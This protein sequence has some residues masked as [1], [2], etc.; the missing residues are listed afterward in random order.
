MRCERSRSWLWWLALALLI[1]APIPSALSQAAPLGSHKLVSLAPF[2]DVSSY[3]ISPDGLRVVYVADQETDGVNE[4]YSIPL[5]GGAS[6]KLNAPLIAGGDVHAFAV[7]PDGQRVV[8]MADQDTDD[9]LEFYSVPIQGPPSAGVKISGPMSPGGNMYYWFLVKFSPDSQRVVYK[10][11]QE[12]P[13]VWDLYSVPIVGPSSAGVKLNRPISG[14]GSAYTDYSITP[15]GSRVVF[16]APSE[17]DYVYDLYSVPIEGPASAAVKLNRTL[18]DG[19]SVSSGPGEVLI[20][21]DSSTVVYR[22]DQDRYRRWELY[23]VPI[24]GPASAG[25]KL[26]HDMAGDAGPVGDD[27]HY[28]RVS[29]DGRRVAF[30]A[31]WVNS[32]DAPPYT[33]SVNVWELYSVPIAGPASAEVKIY[34]PSVV[35]NQGYPYRNVAVA[36]NS[37]PV[38]DLSIAPDGARLV[39]RA[40]YVYTDRSQLYSIPPGGPAS[41]NRRLDTTVP[42]EDGGEVSHYQISPD[43]SRVVYRAD[44]DATGVSELYSVAV[45]GPAGS[46]I[47]L[48]GTLTSGGAVLN[49]FSISPDGRRVVYRADQESDGV[50]ELYSVPLSGPASAVVKLNGPLVSGGDVTGFALSPDGRWVVYRA[51]QDSNDVFELYA[52]DTGA[53]AGPTPTPTTTSTLT[54]TSSATYPTPTPTTTST[55]TP[56]RSTTYLPL[57]VKSFPFTPAAP[58]LNAI[59]NDDGD[60]TYTVSW[61]PSVGADTYTLQEASDAGFSDAAVVYVGPNTSASIRGRDVGTYYYRAQAAN[62]YASSGW[63]NVRS[64]AVTVET[65]IGD[66]VEVPA[67]S[68]QMGCDPSNDTAS[69]DWGYGD[70][71]PLHAVH[72]DTYWIDRTEVTNAQYA[73]CVA[74][75]SCTPPSSSSSR[76][77]T[78]YYGSPLYNDYPVINVSWHQAKAYCDWAGKRLPT[79]AEWEKAARG[80]TDTRTF[81]WGSTL[82]YCVEANYSTGSNSFCVGDTDIVGSRPLGTSPYGVLNMAGNVREWAADWYA[83]DYYGV[84]PDSNPTGPETGTQRVMRGGSYYSGRLNIRLTIRVASSPTTQDQYSGFRCAAD[85]VE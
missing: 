75:G 79:E 31:T 65:P 28:F 24:A 77:R 11:D 15:D 5:Q 9:L 78:S 17:D 26:N 66:M 44:Q 32:F 8:Y 68:F 13:G 6:S 33:Y 83:A 1:L 48:N 39:Y 12:T 76:Q 46:A 52:T 25:V 35:L 41:A 3:Q 42:G 74:A 21:P 37:N 62:A 16:T 71:V 53:P 55:L 81:P 47:K 64:V 63:S 84:S 56:T 45:A 60:G 59:S 67:G 49:D 29:P 69:C 22:A 7:S 80:A 58:A 4:L 72:L 51:D 10:V 20:S 2:A 30:V 57:V 61:S 23:S 70:E 54:P 14:S 34:G 85:S 73:A 18:P 19:S 27:V 43:S 36:P 38:N 82:P 40:E 50:N